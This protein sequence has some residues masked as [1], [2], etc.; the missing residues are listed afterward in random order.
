MEA[1]RVPTVQV[2]TYEPWPEVTV[3]VPAVVLQVGLPVTPL[4]ANVCPFL[5][6]VKVALSA[7]IGSLYCADTV[8]AVT[9]S[10]ALFTVRLPSVYATV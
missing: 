10:G 1:V 6:P 9:V 3:V 2:M 8:G 5:N 7:G 4:V